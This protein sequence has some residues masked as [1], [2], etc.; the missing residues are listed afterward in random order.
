MYQFSSPH[1]KHIQYKLNLNCIGILKMYLNKAT[2]RSFYMKRHLSIIL[3]GILMLTGCTGKSNPST[4]NSHPSLQK[5]DVTLNTSV[6]SNSSSYE[7]VIAYNTNNY[8]LGSIADFN[9]A[10]VS[11]PDDLNEILAAHADVVKTI[12]SDDENYDFIMET[13]TFSLN[14]LFNEHMG[15]DFVFYGALQKLNRP[16]KELGSEGET[17]YA[18]TC[19]I[20]F[21]VSYTINSPDILTVVERDTTLLTFQTELQN[22]LNT[23]SEDEITNSNIQK[24]LLDKATE[25]TENL[26]SDSIKLLSCEFTLIEICNDGT[27]ITT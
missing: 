24:V 5:E 13:M 21:Q 9:A 10:L 17:T 7:K 26:S 25:L 22:Y 4:A 12:S 11:T 27:Q 6:E 19:F 20:D 18:F 15:D 1:K 8:L 2:E 23:L 3:L 16:N 14:E